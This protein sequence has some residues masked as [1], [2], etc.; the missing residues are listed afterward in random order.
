[1]GI[2]IEGRLRPSSLVD[3][4]TSRKDDDEHAVVKTEHIVT[5]AKDVFEIG[6]PSKRTNSQNSRSLEN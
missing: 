6:E 4:P 2:L 1:M 3:L 5:A